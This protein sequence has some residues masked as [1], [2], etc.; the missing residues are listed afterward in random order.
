MRFIVDSV[1]TLGHIDT[2]KCI[3]MERRPRLLKLTY[4]SEIVARH[5]KVFHRC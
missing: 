2:K 1:I 3:F 4:E 5:A